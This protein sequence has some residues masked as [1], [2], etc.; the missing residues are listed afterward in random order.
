VS[1]VTSGLA[2]A[3]LK[4]HGQSA[5]PA[6]FKGLGVNALVELVHQI[7][8]MEDLPDLEHGLRFNWTTARA[9]T[10]VNKIPDEAEARA[11]IRVVEPGQLEALEAKMRD[12]IRDQ[13]LPGAKV[14][15]TIQRGRPPLAATAANRALAMHMKGIADDM[16]R[17]LVI[18]DTRPRGGTDAAYAG[19]RSPGAVLEH[20]GV[21]GANAHSSRG[22]Y[23]TLG[24]IA[25]RVYLVARTIM[26]IS[27]DKVTR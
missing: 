5:H 23:I 26:D 3:I 18:H 24:S 27:T 8:Q 12:R 16:G 13:Q 14:E 20:L 10:V 15:L 22:E 4:V 21:A 25:P 6:N 17:P 2:Q 11:D 1:L 19:L 7:G 9:G